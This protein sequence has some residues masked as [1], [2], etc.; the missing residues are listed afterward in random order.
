GLDLHDRAAVV[1]SMEWMDSTSHANN[2]VLA[3]ESSMTAIALGGAL[4]IG[5]SSRALRYA[6]FATDTLLP[7]LYNSGVGAA[8]GGGG[9]Y[10]AAMA[11]RLMLL[12]A[13]LEAALGS[14]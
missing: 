3:E 12:R 7:H 10:K 2:R 13:E 4:A 5:D 8:P 14:R 9:Y 11:P 6:R 1:K